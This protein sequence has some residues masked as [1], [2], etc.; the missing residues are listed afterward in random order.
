MVSVV[1]QDGHTAL[2]FAVEEHRTEIVKILL[3]AGTDVNFQEK[4]NKTKAIY[5]DNLCCMCVQFTF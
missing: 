4:V 1:P 5:L 3:A 2:I